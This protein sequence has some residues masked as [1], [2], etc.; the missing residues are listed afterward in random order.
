MAE[1][2]LTHLHVCV[3]GVK[4]LYYFLFLAIWF[5]CIETDTL[6][7]SRRLI[8]DKKSKFDTAFEGESV[9]NMYLCRQIN[10]NLT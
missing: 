3:S 1:P 6:M 9:E 10:R 7:Q 5:F 4:S 8:F 2:S